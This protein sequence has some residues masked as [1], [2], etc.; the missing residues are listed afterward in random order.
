[1]HIHARRGDIAPHHLA[2]CL[3]VMEAPRGTGHIIF[4]YMDLN[5]IKKIKKNPGIKQLDPG[6]LHPPHDTF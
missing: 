6:K 1:M 4:K 5:Q 2:S 3:G